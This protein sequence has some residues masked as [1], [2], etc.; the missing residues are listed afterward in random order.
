MSE[1]E[2]FKVRNRLAQ[3][4]TEPGGMTAGM[5]NSRAGRELAAQQGRSYE[6]IGETL[7]TLEWLCDTRDAPMDSV[8]DL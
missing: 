7:E 3:H 4:V 6:A 5:A 2:V 1:A 8:Y